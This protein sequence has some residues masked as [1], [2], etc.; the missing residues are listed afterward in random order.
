[1]P[2]EASGIDPGATYAGR[3]S[4]LPV[5]SKD[6]QY[7]YPR[8]LEAWPQ[9]REGRVVG[10]PTTPRANSG[11]GHIARTVDREAVRGDSGHGMVTVASYV[12]RTSSTR[13]QGCP[14]CPLGDPAEETFCLCSLSVSCWLIAKMTIV[15]WPQPI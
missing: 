1:M 9:W 14:A 8:H 11:E 13:P 6:R 7:V 3:K 10:L 2:T 4:R 5:L 15:P 12:S